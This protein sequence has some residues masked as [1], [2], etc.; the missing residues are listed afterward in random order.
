MFTIQSK[1]HVEGIGGL[2]IFSFLVDPNDSAYQ[3]WWPGIHLKFH[4]LRGTP[5]SVGSLVYMDEYVGKRRVC[6]TG[7]VSEA[8]PGKRITWQFKALIR[9]PVWLRLE[10]ED[11][12][13]G[14]VITHEIRAGFRGIGSVLD[15]L[16]R[17]YFSETFAKAMDEHAQTEFPR[18]GELL[19]MPVS[20]PI[21]Q[22]ELPHP[23]CCEEARRL[24]VE[25]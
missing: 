2:P 18:L 9:L 20:E 5:G 17:L 23:S 15:V 6:M 25:S 21:Y 16:L 14:V 24:E 11:D 19:L 7:V 4:T 1:V 13:H 3:D 10:L 22:R 8:E 12:N